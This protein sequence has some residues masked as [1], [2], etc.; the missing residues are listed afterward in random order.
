MEEFKRLSQ[1]CMDVVRARDTGTLQ[2]DIFLSEDES[3]C[4]VVERYR[5]SQALV[6][7]MANPADLGQAILATGTVRGELLGEPSPELAA[8]LAEGPVRLF[9]P[10]HRCR[11][12]RFC[13]SASGRDG[14]LWRAGQAR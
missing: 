8:G 12:V 2:Y 3:E 14:R 4:T 11:S 7:H 1:Q 9:R 13:R 5:D 10:L 6:E